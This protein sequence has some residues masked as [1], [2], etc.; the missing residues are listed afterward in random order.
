MA[1]VLKRILGGN[2]GF[3]TKNRVKNLV[4]RS[5]RLFLTMDFFE[6]HTVYGIFGALF[7]TLIIFCDT[8]LWANI[9]R[10]NSNPLL[11]LPT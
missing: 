8:D 5:F 3:C 10:K 7:G 9:W 6:K 11:T 4:F 2:S 1:Q